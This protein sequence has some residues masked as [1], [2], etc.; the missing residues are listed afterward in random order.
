MV[1]TLYKQECLSWS[2]WKL[3]DSIKLEILYH[4]R[5]DQMTQT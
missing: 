5:P 1:D 2:V 3:S 4:I